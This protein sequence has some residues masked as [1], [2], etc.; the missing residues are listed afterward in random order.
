M[1]RL[2]REARLRRIRLELSYDGTAYF[3]WQVQPG[4]PTVQG[5]VQAVL[6]RIEGAP[7]QVHGS[8]RTDAGVHA[9]AQVAACDLGNPIPP[10]NLQRAMNRLLPKDIR[11]TSVSVAES[12]FH[13]RHHALAKTYRY[14]IYR[15]WVCPPFERLYVWHHPYALNEEAMAACTAQFLG[16]HDFRAFTAADDRYTPE[17]DMQRE[18]FASSLRREGTLLTFEVR[19]SGFLKHMV[20]NLMGALIEVGVGNLRAEDVA[21]MLASGVRKSGIRTVPPSGLF[22]VSVE[23]RDTD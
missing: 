12:A 20:R 18:I 21:E 4:L 23:Y 15:E 8:G 2:R 9:L 13:P 17:T 1:H 11:V 3:G 5:E 16:K 22:L 19:G 10:E 14:R 7:V 6:S